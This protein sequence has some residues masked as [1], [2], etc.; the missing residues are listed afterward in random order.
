MSH[1]VIRTLR[2]IGKGHVL[3]KD[4]VHSHHMHA[5]RVE[6]GPHRFITTDIPFIVGVL[7]LVTRSFDI[8]PERLDG[9]WSG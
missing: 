6:D 5:I 8:S 1:P 7:Q 4:L 2:G 9:L 3:A